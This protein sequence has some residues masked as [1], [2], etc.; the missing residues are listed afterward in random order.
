[1]S[2]NCILDKCVQSSLS[3]QQNI[4]IKEHN[5][6]MV[7]AEVKYSKYLDDFSLVIPCLITSLV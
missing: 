2:V 7:F 3:F 5:V 4:I 1:M 6:P